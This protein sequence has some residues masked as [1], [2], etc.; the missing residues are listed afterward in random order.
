MAK[1]GRPVTLTKEQR[2]LKTIK[3]VVNETEFNAI[4]KTA[5]D[6]KVSMSSLL[7]N[8]NIKCIALSELNVVPQD[9]VTE[10]EFFTMAYQVKCIINS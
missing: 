6:R 10:K 5:N 9:N 4:K 3:V 2:R 8:N 1:L 7:R